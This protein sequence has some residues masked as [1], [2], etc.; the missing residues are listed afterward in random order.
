MARTDL[1]KTTAPGSYASTLTKLTMNEGD[2]VNGN[3]YK[4]TGND[5]IV[6]RNT[7]GSAQTI[8]ISST[9]DPYN[10]DGDIDAVSIP[11]G[12]THIFGPVKT[13]GW[14]QTDGYVYLTPSDAAVKIGIVKL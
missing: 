1:T 12:E 3:K 4:C 8:T 10:R 5:L 2:S 9:N 7:D 13:V 14:I 11:A 6:A